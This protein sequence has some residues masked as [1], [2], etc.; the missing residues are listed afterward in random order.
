MR[1]WPIGIS[2]SSLKVY[3]PLWDAALLRRYGRA[4]T[5]SERVLEVAQAA[6]L[7]QR[8]RVIEPS[9]AS[10]NGLGRLKGIVDQAFERGVEVGMGLV[11]AVDRNEPAELDLHWPSDDLP[12][13]AR[14]V[15]VD[16]IIREPY[17]VSGEFIDILY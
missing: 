7:G 8:V 2:S 1:V 11:D 17:P 4:P 10:V 5:T 15:Y 13:E 14:T 12:E 16:R 9:L 3:W 6:E